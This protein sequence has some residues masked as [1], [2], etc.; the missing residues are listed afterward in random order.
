[1][2]DG[3]DGAAEAGVRVRLWDPGL[4]V[5]HWLLA[6]SVITSWSLGE[7]GPADMSLHF[8]SG[9]LVI[10]LLAFRVV[11]GFAGPAPARF[12]HFLTGPRAVLAYARTLRERRPSLWPGHNPMGGW[13]VALILLALAVQAAAGLFA[14]PEDFVNVGPL[15]HLTDAAGRRLASSWH[16]IGGRIVLILVLLHI[17]VIA[18]YYRWKRENLIRPMIDGWKRVRRE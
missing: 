3:G 15:A 18:F 5:F 8:W 11:W 13:A 7:F 9:Y 16:E 2:A 6:A 14:D 1:V 12:A 17:G 4:R 10:A